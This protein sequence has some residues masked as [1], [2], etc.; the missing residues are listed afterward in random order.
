MFTKGLS[1]RPTCIG[2]ER[3][4]THL[5]FYFKLYVAAQKGSH[6]SLYKNIQVS[7]LCCYSICVCSMSIC[8]CGVVSNSPCLGFRGACLSDFDIKFG[9]IEFVGINQLVKHLL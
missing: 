2:T 6:H 7:K 5:L 1:K 8:Q 3:A 4:R 9:F